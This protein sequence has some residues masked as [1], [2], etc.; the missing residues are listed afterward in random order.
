MRNAVSTPVTVKHRLGINSIEEYDF[1]RRFV[2]TVAKAGCTTF[3]VHARNAVLKGLSPKDNREIP[4]LKYDYAYRLKQD[5]P[6]L[7]IVV[8]GGIDTLEKVSAHLEGAD[9][10]MLGRVAYHDP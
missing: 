6:D 10:V 3:L 5:F 9:G 4:P 8:N 2:D 1:V 7:Q